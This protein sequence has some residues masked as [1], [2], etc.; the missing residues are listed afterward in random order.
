[1]SVIKR[2]GKNMFD[3]VFW[4][5]AYHHLVLYL[6]WQ[7]IGYVFKSLIAF[8]VQLKSLNNK[9]RTPLVYDYALIA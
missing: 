8:G 2:I 1:M 9:R 5:V 7:K 4:K 3:L 6:Y